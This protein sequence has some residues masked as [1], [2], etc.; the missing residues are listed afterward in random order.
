MLKVWSEFNWKQGAPRVAADLVTVQLAALLALVGAVLI[1]SGSPGLNMDQAITA[2][3]QYYIAS[4]LPLST[5]FPA[6]F[7]LHGFYTRNRSYSTQWLY[8]GPPWQHW[9]SCSPT[10]C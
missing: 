6:V 1:G 4:F 7:L 5:V 10:S 2:L 9:S 8:K 3:R